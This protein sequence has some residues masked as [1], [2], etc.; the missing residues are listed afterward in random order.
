MDGVRQVM[1]EVMTMPS[2]VLFLVHKRLD[3]LLLNQKKYSKQQYINA[4]E[5]LRDYVDRT[6]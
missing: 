4:C 2:D 1:Q 5:E 3:N 6:C